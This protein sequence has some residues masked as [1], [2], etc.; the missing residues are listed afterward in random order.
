MKKIRR[1]GMPFQAG[2]IDVGAHSVRLD[3][4]EV[5][6]KNGIV[7]LE[8]LSRT[9]NLGYDVFRRGQVSPETLARLSSMLCDFGRKL[10]EY[11]ITLCRVVATSAIR[12]AFNRDLVINRIR[13]DADLELEILETPEEIRITYLAMREALSRRC[14]FGALSGIG[15][16][17][18]TGSLQI[19]YFAHGLMRFCEEIPL[20]TTRLFDAFG[21]SAVSIEQV[22]ETLRS[23]DIGRRL[24]ECVGREAEQP[25]ALIALGAS[26]RV[27]AGVVRGSIEEFGENE[28]VTIDPAAVAP[29]AKR[30]IDADPAG[31]AAE[32]K[33]PE[34]V[35]S[36]VRA[37]SG[38]ISYF[39]EEFRFE[40]FLC[41]GTTTR[42]A[43][44][45]DLVRRGAEGEGAA[46][47]FY[48]DLLGVCDAIGRK[49]GFDPDHASQVAALCLKFLEKLKRTFDFVPNAPLLLE[50]AARLHDIGR[51]VDTRQHHKHSYYLVSNMQL[52]GISN[53]EQRVVA[54][55]C[56]YHRKAPPRESHPEYT[57]LSAEDKVTTLKL[58]A[59]LRVADALDCN[60]RRRF[61]KMKLVLR[62]HTMT[63]VVPESG[64]FRSERLSLEW[65]GGLFN[66]VFGLEL[67]IEE[68]PLSI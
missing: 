20:G 29:A 68:A 54:T 59:I 42:T 3:I 27:F 63:V 14:D 39:L 64:D 37:C 49:Y 46:D 66:Q 44:I 4:F 31:L 41:L 12:E 6:K 60:R 45:G 36:S 10:A 61:D 51:F 40:Q 33:L 15:L 43:L 7:L 30:L 32:F 47:P 18:G 21:R 8:S 56:R 1:M 62:G 23:Q 65:K 34:E 55:V 26:A 58:A 19:F 28:C 16:M 57:A 13:N 22:I 2:I 38:I 5:S 52:P 11:R 17:V 67:K 25:E 53:A 35:A 9:I 50:A 48:R 24:A